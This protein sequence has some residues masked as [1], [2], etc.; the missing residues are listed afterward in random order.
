MNLIVFDIDGTLT[1]STTVDGNCFV[2]AVSE[3]FGFE[4]IDQ[5]WANYRHVTDSG[6]LSQLCTEQLKRL[7]TLDEQERV[8]RRFVTLLSEQFESQPGVH[9]KPTVGASL[10]LSRLTEASSPWK[11]AI[12][13]GGWK[14]SA[15]LKLHQAGL[16][17][18]GIP[19][20][21]AS[22]AENRIDIMKLAISRAGVS[23]WKSVR[24]LYVG[25]GVW[26]LKASR[27]LGIGFVGIGAGKRAQS[28]VV[29]GARFV[30]PDFENIDRFLELASLHAL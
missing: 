29:Q 15:E 5:N 22:D 6:I 3:V 24:K 30:L 27:E 21:T 19:T 10:L 4:D 8:E 20:A 16:D 17:L 12:A 2:Q 18:S 23:D 14:R 28:L 26:D 9:C 1:D 11:V 13:T 7:P 25:D